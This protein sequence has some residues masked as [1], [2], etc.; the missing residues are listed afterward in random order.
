MELIDK[1]RVKVGDIL[2]Y[3]VDYSDATQILNFVRSLCFEAIRVKYFKNTEYKY[4]VQQLFKKVIKHLEVVGEAINMED[5]PKRNDFLMKSISMEDY[6]DVSMS[7]IPISSPIIICVCLEDNEKVLK[8][9]SKDCKFE[10]QMMQSKRRDMD[11]F[12]DALFD[13]RLRNSKVNGDLRNIF[14]HLIEVLIGIFSSLDSTGNISDFDYNNAIKGL[15]KCDVEIGTYLIGCII[16][17]LNCKRSLFE[18]LGIFT[19][20]EE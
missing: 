20:S 3:K 12:T 9:V 4:V 13:L 14:N 11:V 17:R 7:C 19:D 2:S 6:D 8:S 15:H 18:D 1:E 16:Y 10:W 5:V